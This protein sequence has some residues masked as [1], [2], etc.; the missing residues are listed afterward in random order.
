MQ[1]KYGKL[2]EFLFEIYVLDSVAAELMV[3]FRK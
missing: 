3:A 1:G 2:C